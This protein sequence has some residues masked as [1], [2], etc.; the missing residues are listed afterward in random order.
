MNWL[1]GLES[2]DD[3]LPPFAASLA[4]KLQALAQD[5]IYLG[6]SSWKYEGWLGS[7]YSQDH[8]QTRG[9]FSQKKFESDCLRDY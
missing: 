3:P 1:P 4:P 8:Y 2:E 9:K 7:I 5:G 6:T